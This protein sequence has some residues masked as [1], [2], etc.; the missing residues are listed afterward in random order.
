MEHALACFPGSD[1]P[2]E[3]HHEGHIHLFFS[4]N[5]LLVTRNREAV[6]VK[7]SL[8]TQVLTELQV[9]NTGKSPFEETFRPGWRQLSIIIGGFWLPVL[10]CLTML[11]YFSIARDARDVVFDALGLLF[12]FNLADIPGG[13]LHL[14][15]S[16]I[17]DERMLGKVYRHTVTKYYRSQLQEEDDADNVMD[18][19]KYDFRK[20][21]GHP[22]YR[23]AIA[24][25]WCFQ[26]ILPTL[27]LF[28][29][30]VKT[31]EDVE[32]E[33]LKALVLNIANMTGI[34]SNL[35]LGRG[36]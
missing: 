36:S 10:T 17:W 30:Q 20:K 7:L 11:L 13:D 19:T 16:R 28:L 33:E 21:V 22:L 1:R 4:R 18:E 35:T 26:V 8:L 29:D 14:V 23:F 6:S 12:L 31:I 24:I 15:S 3:V 5:A 32:K 27:F 9:K 25:T 2:G 34:P